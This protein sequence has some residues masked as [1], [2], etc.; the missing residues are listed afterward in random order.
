MPFV[1]PARRGRVRL[2]AL[3]AGLILASTFSRAGV[4]AERAPRAK[5]TEAAGSAPTGGL[6][7]VPTRKIAFETDQ[8]TWLSVDVA[9]DMLAA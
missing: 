9:P 4:E 6:P 3:V 2:C 7:L 8:G 1:T 5:E